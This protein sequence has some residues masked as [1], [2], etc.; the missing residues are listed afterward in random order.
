MCSYVRFPIAPWEVPRLWNVVCVS[1]VP[2]PPSKAGRQA[3]STTL[4]CLPQPRSQNPLASIP[5]RQLT[6]P[7]HP[8]SVYQHR[9]WS[10]SPAQ[11]TCQQALVE[12]PI[13]QWGFPT[14]AVTRLMGSGLE[15]VKWCHYMK[16]VL[17]AASASIREV[18]GFLPV[19]RS[20]FSLSYIRRNSS[21]LCSDT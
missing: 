2:R 21:H 15:A 17:L 3:P 16:P 13:L 9:G 12:S 18:M 20:V 4:G 14:E 7:Q 6:C 19:F 5:H 8:G 11:L 10:Y 1:V